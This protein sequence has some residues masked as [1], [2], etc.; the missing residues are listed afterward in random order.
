[1]CAGGNNLGGKAARGE[2]VVFLNPDTELQPDCISE[3]VAPL[4]RNADIGVTGAKM[5][6]PGGNIIQHAGGIV[7]ANG[8]TR[9]RGAGEPGNGQYNTV[10]DTDYGTGAALA[11]SRT[12][13][14]QLGGFDED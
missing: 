2:V 8:M 7:H 6:Y 1:G 13:L 5:L 4:L 12:R 11:I 10:T 9:H 3:L 14:Q